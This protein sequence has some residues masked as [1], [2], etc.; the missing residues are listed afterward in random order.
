MCVRTVFACA[1]AT[2]HSKILTGFLLTRSTY[3]YVL[4]CHMTVSER[5]YK[6]VVFTHRLQS[7]LLASVVYTFYTQGS[8]QEH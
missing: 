4:R 2:V 5:D 8:V 1:C 3:V 6:Q 7:T